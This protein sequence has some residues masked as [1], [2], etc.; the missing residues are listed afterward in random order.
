MIVAFEERQQPLEIKLVV[1][2]KDLAHT[3]ARVTPTN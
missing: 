3:L 2:G 1:D